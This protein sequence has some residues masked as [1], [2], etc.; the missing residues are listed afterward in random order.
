MPLIK[1][2][3]NEA[4]EKNIQEMIEAGHDPK[5]AV[6]ASYAN[7][8]KYKK[9]SDGGMAEEEHIENETSDPHRGVFELQE[10]S[11]MPDF[12]SEEPEYDK[13]VADALREKQNY[14][15]GGMVGSSEG[16]EEEVS[17]PES[18]FAK[19]A[20]EAIEKRKKMKVIN[21]SKE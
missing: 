16:P 20:K 9:M 14:S 6:A 4:R 17:M 2:H 8:R 19:K 21:T 18:A 1:S 3:T 5:Q 11:H 13:M 12:L 7:Q 15:M 10:S